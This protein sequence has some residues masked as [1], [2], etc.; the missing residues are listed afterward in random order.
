MRVPPYSR[1][2]ASYDRLVG[3][4]LEPS[5]LASF[6][7]ARQ[8][9]GLSFRSAADIGCGTGA[10][11]RHLL[12][13]DVPL[14]GVDAS[15]SMLRIAARRLPQGRVRLL[16]QDIR[17]LDLPRPVDLITCNGD[18]LNYIL[19][20]DDLARV[21]QCCHA[22]LSPGGHVFGDLLTGI[23]SGSAEGWWA[24]RSGT[25]GLSFWRMRV[26]P[27]HRLTRVD[28]RDRRP[29][30]AG[31]RWVEETHLQRWHPLCDL[32]AAVRRARLGLRA[33]W[34]L[35]REEGGG[36]G[37]WIQF[38]ARRPRRSGRGSW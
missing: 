4:A 35:Q 23:P 9:F 27:S 11:L 20:S 29:T 22:N 19:S 37:A 12:A 13:D 14:W 28:L 18:T 30:R 36:T 38:L 17:R 1:L 5:I 10:F 34:A 3:S 33:I 24:L 16:R 2:A 31:W 32:R 7:H 15:V 6:E 26:A 21:F 25:E 8:R